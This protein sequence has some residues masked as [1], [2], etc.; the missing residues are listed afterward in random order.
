MRHFEYFRP[1]SLEEALRLKEARPGSFFISGG[2]DLLV[3]IRN[4]EISPEVLISLRSI[5]E[6]EAIEV[7]GGARIGALA[8]ISRLILDEKLG[9]SF[10]VLVE[11]ARSLGSIQ[12]RNAA[13]IGG[14]L[15]NCSPCADMALPLLALEAKVRLQ[16]LRGTREVPIKEFFVGPGES[17]LARDEI[18]TDIILPPPQEKAKTVFMK[19]GRVKMDLALASVAMVLEIEGKMCHRARI[20]AGAVAPV[21]L[22]LTKVETLVEGAVLSETLVA[23][24]Q[25]LASECVSPISDIRASAEYRRQVVGVYVKRGL[26][27]ALGRQ[28]R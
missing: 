5:P 16:S 3:K 12:I 15:C 27:T 24:A 7:N 18:L 19:K 8:T 2:T 14:N 17:C 10:P 1:R 26:L 23:Q 21:P 20:A 22:R 13:T 6:A 25:K 9:Q 11:A 28:E 4:R